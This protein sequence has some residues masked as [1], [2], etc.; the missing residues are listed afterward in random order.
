M[1]KRVFIVIFL[2]AFV[3]CAVA[4]A[5][6]RKTID[7]PK[8]GS[9]EIHKTQPRVV[10]PAGIL[11]IPWHINYQ[12]YLTDN[13][14]NPIDDTLTMTF[15]IYTASAG[16]S[17]LWNENHPTVEIEA[18]LFNEV[19]GVTNPI[20]DSVFALG[21][22][23]WLE[24]A[25]EAQTMS[26][27]TEITSVG[28]AY[29]AVKTD[30]ADEA[31]MVD[32]FHASVSPNPGDLFPLSYGDTEYVNEGQA[33]AITSNMIQ[34]GE[35]ATMDLANNAVI[36]PK[37]MNNAVTS[38]KIATDAVTSQKIGDGTILTADVDPTF[39]AP[40]ADTAD[41]ALAASAGYAD[42]AGVS[43]NS[44]RLENNTLANLDSRW[45]NEGQADAITTSMILDGGVQG[46][47]LASNCVTTPKIMDNAVI[48]DKIVNDAIT[49]DK[50][51]N[52]TIQSADVSFMFIA[53]HSITADYAYDSAPDPDWTISGNYMYPTLPG[54]IGIGITAP[55]SK[56]HIIDSGDNIF[57]VN[58]TT[59]L[60][61]I[62]I[63]SGGAGANGW[64]I[65]TNGVAPS[66]LEFYD[67][68]QTR[69]AMVI[70]NSGNVG[71]NI[72]GPGARLHVNGSAQVDG[73]TQLNGNLTVNGKVAS[74][75]GYDP[76]YV[77]YDNET[78]K[79]IRERVAKEVPAEKSDG[80]VLFWNGETSQFEVYLPA[81]G[82]FRDLVGNTL[83]NK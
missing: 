36:T 33:D 34:N 81:T 5:Q 29:R 83:T 50:I 30:N 39:K 25:V 60:A 21:Q 53:P 59:T 63:A 64:S 71:I 31:D 72:T 35:V 45:V 57:R 61:G 6:Q 42:S 78:R 46:T 13:A 49:S 32:G 16:G 17:E 24:L 44:W 8:F 11:A 20:P 3:V 1:A 55:I 23:R 80:A 48:S 27:R 73:N 79:A 37:I 75:G 22:S 76:P 40:Y 47:D 65:R 77:L 18:G 2:A 7:K 10:R 38:E 52:G 41:Y 66:R 58:S 70:D 56:L 14:S 15:R 68:V 74:L 43:A 67:V 19:L 62:H 28:Y 9:V 4:L 54:S 69:T 82:E 26:P 51:S 12:G